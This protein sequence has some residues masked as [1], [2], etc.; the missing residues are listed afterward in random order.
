[1]GQPAQSGH[2]AG[3]TLGPYRLV[4][5]LGKGGFAH[6]WLA[7][8][9]GP[10]GFSKQVALK[11][12]RRSGE[13]SDGAWA[14]L[15]NEARVGGQ[16]RHPNVVD[17]YRIV[18]HD[19]VW[20]V[21]ME[22]VQGQDLSELLGQMR[23]AGLS[24]PPSVV[25]D[26]GLQVARALEYAHEARD[27][28][29][30][31]LNLVHRDLK[32]ANVLLSDSGAVKVADFGI[33]KAAV[34]LESTTVGSLKGTPYY[35]APEVW[36]GERDFQPRIDLFALGVML[37]E[38]AMGTRLFEG[39]TPGA[40]AAQA[41]FGDP[42]VEASRLNGVFPELGLVVRRL[43][44]RDPELRTQSAAAVVQELRRLAQRVEAPGDLTLFMKLVRASF[45]T[46]EE[47]EAATKSLQVPE[48]VDA[49]WTHL[50]RL[51]R[52]ESVP[53]QL[54][55]REW[56][57]QGRLRDPK[58]DA[59]PEDRAAV[60]ETTSISQLRNA[61]ALPAVMQPTRVYRRAPGSYRR[62]A[63]R[64]ALAVLAVAIVVALG[65]G[66]L[67]GSPDSL[68]E[69]VA[70]ESTSPNSATAAD[71]AP[72]ASTDPL[73]LSEATVL[74]REAEPEVPPA[75]PP[76]QDVATASD[77][78][79]PVEVSEPTP[80]P[81]PARASEQV[82]ERQPPAVVAAPVAAPGCLV[83]QSSP[84]G[85]DV[86]LDGAAAGFA[87]GSGER[88]FAEVSRGSHS[89]VMGTGGNRVEQTVDVPPGTKVVVR[90]ELG[91]RCT[92]R[93]AGPCG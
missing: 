76:A 90:C 12:L 29:E 72:D 46:D 65:V 32:P 71:E 61:V 52:G 42:E 14:T 50:F 83:F 54:Q 38:M 45:G 63:V 23:T 13:D 64:G 22:F 89:V 10:H 11:I 24:L 91:S 28:D 16:L 35:M 78:P 75:R 18:E 49:S 34:S 92:V 21:A 39:E 15:I 79:G 60:S 43:L 93:T 30:N 82:V 47:R 62:H 8:E 1:M 69:T 80:A 57:P 51:A 66:G 31:P 55:T 25:L 27:H 86:L 58:R 68:P 87:R 20:F 17:I 40:M 26:I 6:V 85:A 70:P 77:E 4:R 88:R 41:L 48:T 19:G 81:E 33:A 74:V 53:S 84:P 67:L 44:E 36:A 59:D 7:I 5:Q 73:S 37:W 9:E 3:A 2:Q 56:G